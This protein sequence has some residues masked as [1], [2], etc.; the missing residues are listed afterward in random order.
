[1]NAA[2]VQLHPII[3]QGQNLD[4]VPGELVGYSG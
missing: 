2:T 3:S 1:M 4:F